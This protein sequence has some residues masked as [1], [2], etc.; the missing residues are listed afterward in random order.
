M[1]QETAENEDRVICSYNDIGDASTLPVAILSFFLVLDDYTFNL[2]LI[3]S[4]IS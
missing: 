1:M 4:V 3:K 2:T